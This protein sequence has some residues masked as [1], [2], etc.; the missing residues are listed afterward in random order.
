MS[1]VETTSK[2]YSLAMGILSSGCG[3]GSEQR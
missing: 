2:L 3:M 1:T